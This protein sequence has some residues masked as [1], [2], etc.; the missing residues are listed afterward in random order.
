MRDGAWE[1]N[2]GDEKGRRGRI[3]AETSASSIANAL[4][5]QTGTRVHAWVAKASTGLLH[6]CNGPCC[7]PPLPP[8]FAHHLHPLHLPDCK[9]PCLLEPSRPFSSPFTS[10]RPDRHSLPRDLCAKPCTAP[11]SV[12]APFPAPWVGEGDV[13]TPNLPNISQHPPCH[14][15]SSAAGRTIVRIA[16]SVI[17]WD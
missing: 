8:P 9:P 14:P 10:C 12:V 7:S 13:W 3:G 6:D 16:E 17:P 1:G 11:E 15:P 4:M 2:N 5:R